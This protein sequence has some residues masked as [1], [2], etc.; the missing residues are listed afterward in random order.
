MERLFDLVDE[1]HDFAEVL[2]EELKN[3][4]KDDLRKIEEKYED[5]V[6]EDKTDQINHEFYLSMDKLALVP[7]LAGRDEKLLRKFTE[8]SIFIDGMELSR[9]SKLDAILTFAGIVSKFPT[10]IEFLSN[11]KCFL[12][13]TALVGLP[14]ECYEEYG[15]VLANEK[16][17][18]VVIN[19]SNDT[20]ERID[21]LHDMVEYCE[22]VVYYDMPDEVYKKTISDCVTIANNY[23]IKEETKQ[24]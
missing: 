7:E 11:D 4:R 8:M 16:L 6:L 2:Y 24:K 1:K 12:L 22:E 18:E 13:S 21:M 14:L 10:H 9:G 5:G 3:Q 17:L 23:Q 15:A 19:K 20:N